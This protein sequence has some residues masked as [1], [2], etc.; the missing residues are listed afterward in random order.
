MK[1]VLLKVVFIAS[2]LLASNMA[3]N[4]QTA[5]QSTADS[6]QVAK[7]AQPVKKRQSTDLPISFAGQVGYASP[8]GSWFKNQNGD[9]MS[10][11]G[12]G[13]DFDVLYHFPQMDYKLGVGLT[14]NTSVLFGADLEGFSDI[15]LYGLSLYG[16][17]GQY[18]FFNSKV[19]PYAALSLGLSHFSTPEITMNDVVVAESQNSFGFGI[20]PEI[21]VEFGAFIMSLGY[22]VPMSYKIEDV[23]KTAGSWQITIGARISIFDRN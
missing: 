23:S 22:T 3:V 13:V 5:I 15:G 16:V 11:F 10:T 2:A 8:Q 14:Y 18:R 20:R 6:L 19:S 4:A 21:G 17:K 9:K 1:K 12:I 7:K